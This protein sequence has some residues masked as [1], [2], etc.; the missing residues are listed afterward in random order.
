MSSKQTRTILS[1]TALFSWGD[2]DQNFSWSP[3][4]KWFTFDYSIE[5]VANGEIG[6]ISADGKGKAVN[7]TQN[8][9]ND[10][11]SKWMM[12]GKMILYTSDRDGLRAK[13]NSGGSQGDIWAYLLTQDAWDKFKLGK[14]DAALVQEMEEKA[15][16]ADTGKN[17][18]KKDSSVKI[19]LEGLMY[20][21]AKLTI[22]SSDVGDA[23]VSTNGET[24]YYLAKFE[25]GYNLW[26]TNL[27]TQETKQL[28]PLGADR[29][30]LVWDKDQ[31]NLFIQA[32][33]SIV[34]IDPSI[35]K[36]ERVSVGGDMLLNA[37][38]ERAFMFEHV[39]RRTK[40]TF[41]TAGYHGAPWDSLKADYLKFLPHI[42]NNFEFAEMLS[43]MLGE[44]NVSHCGASYYAQ[45]T[46]NDATASLG[47]FYD[48]AYKGIGVKISEVILEGPLDKAGFNIKPG[49]IIEAIDGDTVAIDKDLSQYLNRKTNKNTLL[50]LFDPA[51]H[52]RKDIIVKPISLGEQADLLYKRWVRRNE[53]EVA[54]L[55]DGKLGYVH[56][57]GM[58]DNSFRAAYEEI[59]GKFGNSKAMVIDTR[60]NGGGDLVSDLAAFLTGKAYMYNATD[61]RVISYEPTFR[62]NRP[63]ISLA[64]EANY[65]D[66]HCYAF[67]YQNLGIGKLVGM[68]TPG[69]CTF[70]GWEMLQ[71]PSLRWG[72]PPVGVKMMDGHYLE[73]HQ[74]TPDIVLMNEYDKV[75]KGEDQQ[76]EAAVKELLS[77]LK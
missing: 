27:R 60:N 19:E 14:E 77:E 63:S 73:N 56:I 37:A 66:G 1:D 10:G 20:R 42:G 31:K 69:T 41:Y 53:A 52:T 47:A 67:G 3:D 44:L 29:A 23:V 24:L 30:Q 2:N 33:G 48:P 65:S 16:K 59:M 76:L 62:W 70:A 40:T 35:G 13:A 28:V 21:K 64:N 25:K 55:S 71:D 6:I 74:T 72:V 26:T 32:D 75:S 68:P 54:K 36:Q 51:A 61:K 50:S 49:T 46:N 4:G 8:G 57:P 11:D 58:N 38:E 5:G 7:I 17:K 9:F 15:A 22:N 39:W 34:K 12:D 45:G 43:E 18:I